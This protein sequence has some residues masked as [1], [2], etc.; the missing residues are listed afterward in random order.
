MLVHR[1]EFTV[2]HARGGDLVRLLKAGIEYGLPTPPYG[3]RIYRPHIATFDV[4][5]VDA[6]FDSLAQYEAFWE[7]FWASPRVDEYIEKFREL[8][9][10]GGSETIWDVET[11]EPE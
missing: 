10:P 8:R 2:K 11:V 5:I 1:A 3:I 9:E 6:E 7:G 4:V